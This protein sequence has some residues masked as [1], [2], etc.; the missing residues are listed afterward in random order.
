MT[1]AKSLVTVSVDSVFRNFLIDEERYELLDVVEMMTQVFFTEDVLV[2]PPIKNERIRVFLRDIVDRVDLG[3]QSMYRVS[4]CGD[5]G[6][7]P[8]IVRERAR[9]AALSLHAYDV[10]YDPTETCEWNCSMWRWALWSNF[11][12]LL[13]E[14]HVKLSGKFGPAS[15]PFSRVNGRE[16]V[17][18]MLPLAST[19]EVPSDM[20]LQS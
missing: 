5:R 3:A 12:A 14:E 2:V 8:H 17:Q 10:P 19:D 7:V 1:M 16:W 6:S 13:K 15:F 9:R 4:V 20:E 18:G 11:N